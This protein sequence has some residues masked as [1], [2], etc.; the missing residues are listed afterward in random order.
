MTALFSAVFVLYGMDHGQALTRPGLPD[1]GMFMVAGSITAA[2]A[3]SLRVTRQNPWIRRR[4]CAFPRS[5]RSISWRA[6]ATALS[7]WMRISSLRDVNSAAEQILEIDRRDVMGKNFWQQFPEQAGTAT[8]ISFRRTMTQKESLRFEYLDPKTSRWFEIASYPSTDGGISIFFRDITGS[9]LASEALRLSEE[10][11]RVALKQS[12]IAVFNLDSE[13]RL[14]WIYNAQAA[15]WRFRV[16]APPQ[17][18]AGRRFP[19]GAVRPH[20][21]GRAGCAAHAASGARFYHSV[22]DR[23]RTARLRRDHRTVARCRHR[24]LPESPAR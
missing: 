23:I 24:R 4:S 8:R 13:L 3:N 9:K 21:S 6:S 17:E 15:R 11:F 20:R 7:R 5:A 18:Q 22:R 10:R 19:A 14:T 1:R 12:P 16:H 2:I